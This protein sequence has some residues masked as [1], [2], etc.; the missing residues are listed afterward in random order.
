MKL[1]QLASLFALTTTFA[2]YASANNSLLTDST[3]IEPLM[4][5]IPSGSYYMGSDRGN[6]DEQ[7]VR[8]VEIPGFHIG[9]YEVTFA[10]FT[11]FANATN[12]QMDATCY[13]Y[14]LGGP[15]RKV[16]GTW[17][18]NIYKFGDFYPVVCISVDTA[19]KYAQWLS[20]QT[21]KH[22]RL[23]SEAEW[24]YVARAGTSTRFHYGSSRD[25]SKAC[26]Y[27][28]VS[29]WYAADKSKELFEGANVVEIEK[30]SD[31]EAT[32][33]VVG[34]YKP[35]Q[36]GL[37]DIMGNVNEYVQDCYK[38]TYE[39][40]PTDGSA[41]L[42]DDCKEIVVRGGSWHWFPWS[43]S[44]RYA[45]PLDG[46]IGA[47]EGFRLVLETNDVPYVIS[48]NTK[49]FVEKLSKEQ[50]KVIAKHQ[51]IDKYPQI[52]EGLKLISANSNGV[53]LRWHAN[54]EPWVTGYK[55]YRQDPLNNKT[56]SISGE[57]TETHYIDKKPLEQNAR[58]YVV[59]LN[60]NTE[61]QPSN[62]IDS[63]FET[64]HLLP[65]LVQG[66]AYTFSK[67]HEVRLSGMEPEDDKLY[68]HLSEGYSEYTVETKTEK[69][70]QLEA[71]IFH[72]GGKQDLKIWLGDKLVA[73]KAIEG[74]RGWK[75]LNGLK[76]ILPQGKS[77][78]RFKGSSET[79]GIN[80]LRFSG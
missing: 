11:K 38:D 18:N 58:Y 21:G 77:L 20:K 32:L 57:I 62:V 70:F 51:T 68:L 6:S 74:D 44:R 48:N 73:N 42:I 23:P 40:A 47:L 24:E 14:V 46:H 80:W 7:P 22:Y 56:V 26:Q 9:K 35:N 50:Q 75:T 59:A 28:N 71:R 72:S 39:G 10:E 15:H 53:Q 8:K 76:V 37:Y 5:E 61:S 12:F 69:A 13:Q 29:D 1:L 49:A 31:N 4:V 41:V 45:L 65:S 63:N 34:L 19:K 54:I 3:F 25:A 17:N 78:L 36:F 27:A 30:C 43:S 2:E 67:D 60:K 79:F 64:V 52:P 16:L 33:S 66:E 55:V